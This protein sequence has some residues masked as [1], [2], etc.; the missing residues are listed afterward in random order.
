M[1]ILAQ[2]QDIANFS[3]VGRRTKYYLRQYAN[4]KY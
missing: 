2:V 1:E 4:T 3:L